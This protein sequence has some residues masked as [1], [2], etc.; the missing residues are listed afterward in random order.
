MNKSVFC[1]SFI[2]KVPFVAFLSLHRGKG[3]TRWD[4]P[5]VI[6][7]SWVVWLPSFR[8]VAPCFIFWQEYHFWLF[9]FNTERVWPFTHAN[10]PLILNIYGFVGLTTIGQARIVDTDMYIYVCIHMYIYIHMYDKVTGT[11]NIFIQI[12]P[13]THRESQHCT[14]SHEHTDRTSKTKSEQEIYKW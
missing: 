11:C 3:V 2:F 6:C 12:P 14:C 8:S 13:P 10:V 1:C 5:H 4:P 7:K 9:L